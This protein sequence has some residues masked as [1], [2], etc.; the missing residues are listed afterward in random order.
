MTT[1]GKKCKNTIYNKFQ[2][3]INLKYYDKKN[4]TCFI[5]KHQL[6]L[7]YKYF[8]LSKFI[9]KKY[10]C[11]DIQGNINKYIIDNKYI[12]NNFTNEFKKKVAIVRNN[13]NI[14]NFKKC[15]NFAIKNSKLLSNKMKIT[16]MTKMMD[17]YNKLDR[18]FV[19]RKFV[20]N[21]LEKLKN[22]TVM[23]NS[24]KTTVDEFLEL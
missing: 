21:V 7:M 4:P 13:P 20:I 17:E 6:N 1:K 23:N 19:D 3:I 12:I 9:S 5:Y 15:V 24:L 2:T 10:L 22:N 16:I 14:H 8:L 11:K 18:K